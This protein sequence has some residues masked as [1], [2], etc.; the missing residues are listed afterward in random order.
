[1]YCPS[2]L[3]QNTDG[4]LQDCDCL[5]GVMGGDISAGGVAQQPLGRHRVRTRVVQQCG[6][7]VPAPMR[8]G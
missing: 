8:R 2:I 5:V 7:G 4:L 1:M 6:E 3:R